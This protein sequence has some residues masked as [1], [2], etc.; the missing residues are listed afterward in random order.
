MKLYYDV[1]D[2]VQW[3]RDRYRNIVCNNIESILYIV[4]ISACRHFEE[5]KKV[6]K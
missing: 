1:V 6:N 4:N 5:E 2:G 3:G